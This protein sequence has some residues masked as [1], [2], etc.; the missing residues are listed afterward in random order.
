[1]F[2]NQTELYISASGK[3]GNFGCSVYNKLFGLNKI[4]SIYLPRSVTCAEQLISSIK[5]LKIKGCS[6]SMPL[7]SKVIPFLDELDSISAETNSV[8][9]IV[10]NNGILKGWNTDFWGFK[11]AI[12]KYEFQS[13]IIYG[14]G[15]VVHS[16]LK[17]LIEQNIQDI[18]ITARNYGEAQKIGNLYSVKSMEFGELSKNKGLTKDILINATPAGN[19]SSHE[20][21]NLIDLCHMVFDLSVNKDLNPLLKYAL[22]KGKK[23]IEGLEMCEYQLQKQM[24]IYTGI[25]VD[26]DSIHNIVLSTYQQR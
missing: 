13:A 8:N 22:A 10:N 16:I 4:D 3:P 5:C 24:L 6:V 12:S 7:K 19:L 20:M 17:A 1:M 25:E 14:S 11:E 26:I 21:F 15:S 9:T 23:A 18:L 2:S